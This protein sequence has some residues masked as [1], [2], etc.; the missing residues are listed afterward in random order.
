MKNN[1]ILLGGGGHA[2]A[3]L[4]VVFSTDKYKVLGYIDKSK[5]LDDKFNVDYLGDDDQIIKYVHDAVFLIAIGQLKTPKIRV[6]IFNKALSLGAK[7][8]V[9]KSPSAYVSR[10]S[11]VEDGTIIMH[12]VVIQAGVQIGRNCI[13]NDGALIEHDTSI[14][15]HCH[16]STS[17]TL[18]GNVSVGDETFLGSGTIVKNGLTIGK[19]VVVGAG[20]VVVKDIMNGQMVY[21]NPARLKSNA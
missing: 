3:C 11:Y 14:G 19:N 4:D 1:I 21:G 20:S 9:I 17:T 18:N 10:F 2:K 12:N 16:I 5:T 8:P 6:E 13:V 15:D 7:F